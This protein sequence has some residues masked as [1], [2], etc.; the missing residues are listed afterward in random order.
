[1]FLILLAVF[2]TVYYHYLQDPVFHQNAYALLTTIVVFRSM[3]LM[4]VNLRPSF[5]SSDRNSDKAVNDRD[6]K[7]LRSMWL[8]V[9]CGLTLFIGGFGIWS[10]D[11][12]YCPE[13]RAWRRKMGLPWGILLEGH[14]WWHIG[15]GLGAYFYITWAIWLRHCLNGR[16]EEYELD[17]PSAITTLPQIVRSERSDTRL[18]SKQA[19]SNGKARKKQ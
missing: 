2:I 16:Q 19:H 4:E 3:Y 1:M 12:I 18:D 7:I 9:A 17:W 5:R 6:L 8:M 14:G 15:T 13:L 10:L 11:S